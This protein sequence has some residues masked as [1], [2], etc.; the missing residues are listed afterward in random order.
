MKTL[1]INGHNDLSTSRINK[2]WLAELAAHHPD[3]ALHKLCEAHTHCNFDVVKEQQLLLEHD[4]IV[5]MFPVHWYGPTSL[6]H[7]WIEQVLAL[8]FAYGEGGDKMEGKEMMLVMSFGGP[9]AAYSEPNGYSV[10]DFMAP[11][12]ATAKF[13]RMT[14]APMYKLHN[15][16]M[17]DDATVLASAKAMAKHIKS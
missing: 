16:F 12:I 5:F 9:E 8:G 2:T 14:M 10:N 13:V 17:L 7:R 1:V 3:V 4:R 6:L 11:L 15:I